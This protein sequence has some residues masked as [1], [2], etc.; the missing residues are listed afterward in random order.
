M[1]LNRS[2]NAFMRRD[3]LVVLAALALVFSFSLVQPKK[4]K[5]V[6]GRV[7]CVSN[8]HQISLAMRMWSG[9]HTERFPMA[10]STNQGGSLEFIEI[11]DTSG[12]FRAASNELNSPKILACSADRTRHWA[13]N[14]TNFGNE[15]LSYFLALDADETRP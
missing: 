1:D 9:D 11:G 6:K 2:K 13:T 12:H 14:F 8:L 10:V 3:M 15:N 5:I 4:R 7:Q